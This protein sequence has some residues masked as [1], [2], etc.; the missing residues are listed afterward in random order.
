[1]DGSLL[2]SGYCCWRMAAG[3]LGG[4]RLVVGLMV[5]TAAGLRWGE[6]SKVHQGIY[7]YN[8]ALV[9]IALPILLPNSWYLWAWVVW[10]AVVSVWVH[11]ALEKALQ[12]TGMRVLTAPFVIVTWAV[13]ALIHVLNRGRTLDTEAAEATVVQALEY[14]WSDVVVLAPLR[15]VAQIFLLDNALVGIAFLVG[16]VL[17]SRRLVLLAWLA[18]LVITAVA[19]ASG[20]EHLMLLAGVYAFNSVLTAI[21]V[22]SEGGSA[23]WQRVAPP[24]LGTF[25]SFI[26]FLVLQRLLSSVYLPAL[27]APFVLV[28]WG[29]DFV[30][31]RRR[32][33]SGMRWDDGAPLS[34]A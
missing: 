1:M 16:L 3:F 15:G 11:L 34:V 22:Y 17:A 8:G 4:I 30:N 33:R 10:G 6:L 21:A 14:G 7:G 9:G 32:D 29:F 18:S 26:V 2:S 12:R 5:G 13:C 24:L 25:L 20:F 23:V 19:Y 28:T 31:A 27:T